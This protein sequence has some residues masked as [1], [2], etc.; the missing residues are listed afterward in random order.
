MTSDYQAFGVIT[1]SLLN[2]LVVAPFLAA[3]QLRWG[4]PKAS[5][6]N[7]L[8]ANPNGSAKCLPAGAISQTEHR[9]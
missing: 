4:Q 8:T 2:D 6:E 7:S 9:W 1:S 5:T 3:R